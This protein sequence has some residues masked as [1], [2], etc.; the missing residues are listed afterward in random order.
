MVLET[1][2]QAKE[3]GAF[4][5]LFAGPAGLC[6]VPIGM[7]R[8]LAIFVLYAIGCSSVVPV[9]FAAA[10]AD[11]PACCRRDGKHHCESGMSDMA[12]MSQTPANKSG[13]R[14]TAPG[15]PHRSLSATPAPAGQA[16]PSDFS[17]PELP[18]ASL[19][20]LPPSFGFASQPVLRNS[21]RGPPSSI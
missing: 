13:L 8:L 14:A 12:E 10:Y 1:T 11:T 16:A 7:R 17:S 15:C 9:A 4:A 5:S 2:G 19:I 20:C 3:L 18:H 21:E 6:Y